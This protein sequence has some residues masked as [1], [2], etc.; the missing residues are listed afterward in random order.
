MFV[1][2]I[3]SH[4]G[5]SSP[6]VVWITR[7]FSLIISKILWRIKYTN[8]EN[9]PKESA[10]GLI[11]SANHQTYFDPFWICI[12]VKREMRFMAWNKAFGWIFIGRWLRMLGAFPVSLKRGGT[13][14]ALKQTLEFLRNGKT[15]VIFPEGEREFADGKLLPFKTGAVRIALEANVPILPVT[16]VGGNRIWSRDHKFPRFGKVE[17]IYHP[18]IKF[19]NQNTSHN[20]QAMCE[21]LKKNIQN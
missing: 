11:I 9:I 14:K 16:V 17:I 13:I 6:L 10:A 21:V 8:V 2:K 4:I 20:L 18:V 15:V 5:S 19:S 12:P 1:K 3:N 7:Y